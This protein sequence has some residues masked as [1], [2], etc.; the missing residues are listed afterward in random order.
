MEPVKIS[1]VADARGAKA[2]D[3]YMKL[4]WVVLAVAPGRD[5]D[6]MAYN[7]YSLGWPSENGDAKFPPDSW[8]V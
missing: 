7:L 8:Y 3:E 5:E 2:A 6:G 4:G 1:H